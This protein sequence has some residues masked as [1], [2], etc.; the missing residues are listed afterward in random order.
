MYSPDIAKAFPRL[1]S[2]NHSITSP[3]THDYN[4]IAWAAGE[5]DRWWWPVP[6]GDYWPPGVARAATVA[7]FIE[8][9][10][11]KGYT[12]CDD[13]TLQQGI[14]KVVLY[15]DDYGAPT[16]MARQLPTGEWTSKCGRWHDLS[17]TDTDVIASGDYGT[18]SVYLCRLYLL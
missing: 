13:G 7:A 12:P 14:E 5:D 1:K 9:F 16:H 11:T 6:P 18:A 17:H 10:S 4:C 3:E 15:I 8:A 2:G